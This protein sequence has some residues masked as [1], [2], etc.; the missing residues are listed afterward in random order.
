MRLSEIAPMRPKRPGELRVAALKTAAD[1][2]SDALRLERERKR[3]RR[4]QTALGKLQ[5]ARTR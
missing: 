2:A 5:R 3:L 4:A 1:Q